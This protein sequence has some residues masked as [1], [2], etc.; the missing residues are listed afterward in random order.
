MLG[1]LIWHGAGRPRVTWERR[2][3]GGVTFC[4]LEAWGGE[5]RI[6]RRIRRTLGE[7]TDRG[8]RRWIISPEWPDVWR[9]GLVEV[10]EDGLRQALFPQ[11]LDWLSAQG[12]LSLGGA[13]VELSAPWADGAVWETARI[14]GRRC[15]YLRLRVEGDAALRQDLWRRYGIAVVGEESPASLQVC[16]GRS[17][18]GVPALFLGS[19]CGRRQ[20]AEYDLPEA[21][22]MAMGPYPL[23]SQLAA[24]LWQ[25]GA[26]K[27]EDVRLKSLD[28]PA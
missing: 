15:R 22:S 21:V 2:P 9:E 1:Y 5:R 26:V 4:V 16:F 28:F 20:R 18:E 14:L 24:A 6:N 19:G 13:T 8:V 3:I 25:C 12:R 23:T 10:E 27:T 7:L 17:A 11:M